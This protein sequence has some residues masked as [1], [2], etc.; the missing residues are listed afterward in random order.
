MFGR[1]ASF[2][3]HH[4]AVHLGANAISCLQGVVLGIWIYYTFWLTRSAPDGYVMAY[5]CT[6]YVL[7]EMLTSALTV[8]RRDRWL[9]V[10]ADNG[11]AVC[12]I[13][14]IGFVWYDRVRLLI[15]GIRAEAITAFTLMLVGSFL[16]GLL[17]EMV[18][19]TRTIGAAPINI[20]PQ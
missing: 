14:Q 13:V 12:L 7:L 16:I 2:I 3:V 15:F 4:H 9:A 18:I 8:V 20:S 19:N 10:L 6:I 11:V 17:I 5:I 1:L